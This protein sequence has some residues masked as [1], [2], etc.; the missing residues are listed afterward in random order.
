MMTKKH[1]II[2]L[3]ITVVFSLNLIAQNIQ[4]IIVTVDKPKAEIKPEMWVIFFED[5]NFG[6]DGGIYAEMVKNRSFEFAKPRTGWQVNLT[7]RDSS[8]FVIQNRGNLNQDNPRY[9]RI[10][11]KDGT[12]KNY[13][14]NSG[15]RGMGVKPVSY[16]HL[17]LPTNRE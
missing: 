2:V 12:V 10:S 4:P 6:A 16:T 8:H 11:I 3:L 17:T 9:V 5:I 1:T 14:S 7:S 13:I 15:F